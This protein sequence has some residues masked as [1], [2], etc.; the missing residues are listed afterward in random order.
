[1]NQEKIGKFIKE[2]RKNKN[3]TQEELGEYLG[4]S[5]RSISKYENGKCMPDISL[6][7]PLCDIL[8]ISLNELLSGEYLDEKSYKEKAEINL[9]NTINYINKRD[10]CFNKII[11]LLIVLSGV[12]SL[13]LYNI[14]SY[15]Y[16]YL[17][18]VII[19]LLTY[20]FKSYIS[21]VIYKFSN[22]IKK[23]T[24]I[25]EIIILLL[26]FITINISL[27]Y[28]NDILLLIISIV[29]LIISIH[30]LLKKNKIIITLIILFVYIMLL[31]CINYY[32]VI[33]NSK[34]I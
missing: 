7:K 18:L 13:Y 15:L 1:M 11:I 3:L 22:K 8:N 23:S 14:H 31:V 2:C 29:L 21:N 12:L 19:I 6:F 5:N 25:F 24:N 20:I 26:S 17:L 30:N 32:I 27:F 10:T 33:P 28:L 9:S 34:L 4:V 16:I